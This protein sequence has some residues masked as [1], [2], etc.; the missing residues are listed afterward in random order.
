MFNPF[1]MF[2]PKKMVGVDI[3][4]SSVKVVEISRWGGGKTLENYGEIKSDSFY[5]E[6]SDGK[7]TNSEPLSNDFISK[8]IRGILDESQIKT[9]SVIFSI[10]DSSTFCTSFEI[11]FMTEKEIPEAIYYNASQYITMPISEV[12]LDWKIIPNPPGEKKAAMKVFLVA[13]PNRIV[14]EYKAMAAIAGL[15]LHAIEAEALGVTRALIKTSQKTV[16]LIDIGVQSST[17]NIIYKGFL[18]S[19]YSFNFNSGQLSRIV[20][21]ALGVDLKEAENIKNKEGLMHPRQDVVKTLY[22]LLDPL[23]IEIESVCSEFLYREQKQ[24]E[25][26]YLTG[27]TANL[28]GLKE[29]FAESLKKN[30]YVPNC[31][32]EFLYPPILEDTL[33]QM[34]PS[35]SAAV[36]VALGGLEA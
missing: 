18:K 12:T 23:L 31:F 27:G 36:G 3:G 13:V 4:A 19:S 6:S 34:A 32:S 17:I 7:K 14:Q 26:I 5:K 30:V 1:K 35:F 15:K 25:E 33:R 28:P 29:Y 11:P 8:A 10:P 20:S 21:S 16:C 9:K 22:M 2:F 24:I